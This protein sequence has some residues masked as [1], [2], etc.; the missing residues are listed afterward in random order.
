MNVIKKREIDA[1]GMPS[2]NAQVIYLLAV[3]W[4]TATVENNKVPAGESDSSEYDEVVTTKD[5]KTID[6][7][8]SCIIHAR[9]GTAYTGKGINVITQ[10]LHAEDGSFPQGLTV[11]KYLYRVVQWQQECCCGS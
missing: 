2:V 6:A 11:Q 1:L 10:A 7:F 8:S 5:T 4:A 9:M 3:L